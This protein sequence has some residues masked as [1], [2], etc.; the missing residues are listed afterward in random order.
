MLGFNMM[1]AAAAA[2]MLA[3]AASAEEKTEAPKEKKVCR[4]V[5]MSGRITP[6]RVCRKVERK[7]RQEQS[8]RPDRPAP[9][10]GDD[11]D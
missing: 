3:P 6:E 2:L 4:T 9:E 8:A 10:T 1:A 7:A 11:S 5:Q